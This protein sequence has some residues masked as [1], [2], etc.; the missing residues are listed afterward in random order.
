[1]YHYGDGK[2]DISGDSGGTV[3][4]NT[5]EL[6]IGLAVKLLHP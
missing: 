1:V 4:C 3:G 2:E 5:G 6:Q